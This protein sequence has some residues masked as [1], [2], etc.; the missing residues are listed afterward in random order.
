M[1]AHERAIV[2]TDFFHLRSIIIL[3]GNVN[4]EPRDLIECAAGFR[5]HRDN[6]SEGAVELLDQIVANNLVLLIPG[7][8]TGNEEKASAGGHQDAVGI[9]AGGAQRFGI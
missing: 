5:N 1:L 3:V 2:L 6:V 9:A 7:Y 8:L 4:S